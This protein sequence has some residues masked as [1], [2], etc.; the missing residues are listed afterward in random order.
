MALA[1]GYP[2][3]GR[4]PAARDDENDEPG[5]R[6][7][8]MYQGYGMGAGGWLVMALILLGTVGLIAAVTVAVVRGLAPDRRPETGRPN[9]A[10]QVLADRF[11]R[12]EIDSEEYE[13][14]LRTL[15]AER[16]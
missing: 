6:A 14:R 9:S 10:E 16:R 5:R 15:R 7:T 11:A 13:S 4:R 3:S 8:V 12:G 1:D 2:A